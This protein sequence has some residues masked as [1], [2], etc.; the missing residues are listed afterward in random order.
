[1]N[2][3]VIQFID[4]DY[5][6]LMTLSWTFSVLPREGDLIRIAAGQYRVRGPIEWTLGGSGIIKAFKC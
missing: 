1:M 6:N 4:S 2:N 5:A 3:V